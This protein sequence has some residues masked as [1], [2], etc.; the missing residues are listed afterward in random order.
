MR[1]IV[2]L[3]SV[4][5]AGEDWILLALYTRVLFRLCREWRVDKKSHWLRDLWEKQF[6]G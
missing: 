4:R 1:Y 2:G 6:N 5:G 3:S